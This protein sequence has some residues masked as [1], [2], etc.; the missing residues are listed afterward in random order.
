MVALEP[1]RRA[2]GLRA[3]TVSTYQSISGAGRRALGDFALASRNLLDGEPPESETTAFDAVPVIGEL[4]DD[5]HT[6]EEQKMKL[7]A[8]KILGAE[9]D[10]DVCCVRVPVATSH[11]EHVVVR[12]D[13]P[14]TTEEAIAALDSAPGIQLWREGRP[15]TPRAVAGT[16]AVH[17]GRIRPAATVPHGF[18]MWVVSDNLRK[19]AALNAV[20]IAERILAASGLSRGTSTESQGKP[21]RHA[22]PS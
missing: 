18:Q 13:R 17:V 12:T 9:F 15:P 6:A 4:D 16:D 2:F 22:I 11:G 10:L 1:I 14:V 20:Q 5:G 21:A 7:E 8:P 19:G 3:A